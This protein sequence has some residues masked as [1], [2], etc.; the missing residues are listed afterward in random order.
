MS[1]EGAAGGRRKEANAFLF[2]GRSEWAAE[3][4]NSFNVC[5]SL[6]R[7]TEYFQHHL[8]AV[9]PSAAQ[10][11]SQEPLIGFSAYNGFS[12]KSG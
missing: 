10:T 1:F 9:S 8:P 7:R 4:G 5:F 6:M 11:I 2:N 3:A 12:A